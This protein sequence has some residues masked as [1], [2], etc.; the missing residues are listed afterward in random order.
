MDALLGNNEN[1]GSYQ[2]FG[3]LTIDL[4]LANLPEASDFSMGL[5][6]E[7]GIYTSQWN[8]GD[9]KFSRYVERS[10]GSSIV[11]PC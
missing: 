2:V 10:A 3:S 5:D 8:N 4:D 7:T 1:Y 9:V 6:L 11:Q